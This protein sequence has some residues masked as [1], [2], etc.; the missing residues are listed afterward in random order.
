M[1]VGGLTVFPDNL[2]HADRNGVTTILV[3]I[4]GEVADIGAEFVAAETIVLDVMRRGTPTPSI[5]TAA[6]SEMAARATANLT[7]LT[8]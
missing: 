2:P 4:A 1:R 8:Q 5:L 7:R 6:R 3:E